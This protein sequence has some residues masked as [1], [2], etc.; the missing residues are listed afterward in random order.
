MP[1]PTHGSCVPRQCNRFKRGVTNSKK[2]RRR[3][4]SCKIVSDC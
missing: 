4:W 3:I 2:K 1:H